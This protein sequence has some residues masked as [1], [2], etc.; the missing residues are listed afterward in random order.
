L[1]PF[2]FKSHV[3][4]PNN[5]VRLH[6]VFM[7]HFLGEFI[8]C[9]ASGLFPKLGYC[10]QCY[11]KRWCTGVSCILT[12]VPLGRSPGAVSL[13]HTAVLSLAFWGLSI[14]LS[15]VIELIC[16][17]TIM[18]CVIVTALEYGHSNL[19]EMKCKCCFDMHLCYNQGNWTL[20][21]V[22]TGHWYVFLWEFPV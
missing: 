12:Y 14:L 22:F 17:Y 5:L 7:P 4:I 20:L 2:T 6:S 15:I 10:E 13:D 21:H 8:S 1:H 18:Y 16:I 11:D 9:R 19:D 3:V